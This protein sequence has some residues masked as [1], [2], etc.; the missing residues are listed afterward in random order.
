MGQ[1]ESHTILAINMQGF[2]YIYNFAY[3]E[4]QVVCRNIDRGNLLTAN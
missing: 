3:L 2:S 1:C 4:T